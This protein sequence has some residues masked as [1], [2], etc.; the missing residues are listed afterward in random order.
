DDLDVS[1]LFQDAEGNHVAYPRLLP[2]KLSEEFSSSQPRRLVCHG[3]APF[4]IF[5]RLQI[6]LYYHLDDDTFFRGNAVTLEMLN[7]KLD[8]SSVS[9]F[10]RH[11]VFVPGSHPKLQVVRLSYTDDFGSELFYSPVEVMQFMYTIGSGAAVREYSQ[12]YNPA[13]PKFDFTPLGNHA[14]IQ[15]LS[16]PSWSPDI[17][18]VTNLI[19]FLPLLSDLHT[20]SPSFGPIPD[21]V[22]MDELPEHIILD[23]AP[24]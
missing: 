12:A 10:R 21:G 14:C 16:L 6:N 9:M 3:A 24:M 8:R 19:E 18:Q 1:G 2:L 4:P 7:M 5:R 22:T 23:Y 17:W 13:N 11:K 15:V 20:S